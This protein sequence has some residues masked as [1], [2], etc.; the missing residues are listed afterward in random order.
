MS[1]PIRNVKLYE[2]TEYTAATD[3]TKE[4]NVQRYIPMTQDARLKTVK[5]IKKTASA[6]RKKA[7]Y[8]SS[9][10]LAKMRTSRAQ[11]RSSLARSTLRLSGIDAE[12][13]RPTEASVLH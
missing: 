3:D 10:A 11:L 5:G 6:P 4:H 8:I 9:A 13:E 1:F 12:I 2:I 7:S